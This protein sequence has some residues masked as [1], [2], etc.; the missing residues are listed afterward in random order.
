MFKGYDR[1]ALHFEILPDILPN[2]EY[3][4]VECSVAYV[5]DPTSRD[6]VVDPSQRLP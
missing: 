4:F 3:Q 6:D 5:V 2:S 1:A